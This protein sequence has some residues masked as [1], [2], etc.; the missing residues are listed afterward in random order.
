M[1]SL[2]DRAVIQLFLVIILSILLLLALHVVPDP[3]ALVANVAA[4]VTKMN[5]REVAI[6]ACPFFPTR[7]P[8]HESPSLQQELAWNAIVRSQLTWNAIVEIEDVF[9]FDVPLNQSVHDEG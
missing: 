2:L 5:G 8:F 7:P 1:H 9:S 6:I 4:I 3:I